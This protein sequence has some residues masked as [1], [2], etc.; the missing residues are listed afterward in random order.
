MLGER[1]KSAVGPGKPNHQSDVR[2]VQRL[3]DRNATFAGGNIMITGNFDQATATAI[4]NFQHRVM[5]MSFAG[6]VI[7][8]GDETFWRLSESR[9]RR[10]LAGSLGGIILAPFV[11]DVYPSEDEIV[12]AAKTLKCEARTIK[13]VALVEAPT[14]GFDEMGRPK[15]LFE[16]HIFSQ[17]TMRQYDG[18]YPFISNRVRGNYSFPERNQYVR[19]QHAYALA[20]YAALQA[21]SWGLFQIL[22]QNFLLAGFGTV[23]QFVRAMCY[24]AGEHLAAFVAFAQSNSH[25]LS[26]L[27]KKD[28]AQIAYYFNGPQYPEN[29]Y[30]I[31]LAKK[32]AQ[33]KE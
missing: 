26:A 11:G 27:R 23:E 14:G 13:A 12:E 10:M 32:Y 29:Q 3:L 21:T 17:L 25:L 18:R 31:K 19:L 1:L 2:T 33:A 7:N 9:P 28:W 5:R 15:I 4:L 22:G 30:D 6:G 8:P 24:S 16:R 20:P